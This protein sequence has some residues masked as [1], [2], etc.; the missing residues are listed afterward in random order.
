MWEWFQTSDLLIRHPCI[1]L[2]ATRNVS[3]LSVLD[4]FSVTGS[5][6]V[7]P[8]IRRNFYMRMKKEKRWNDCVTMKRRNNIL[9]EFWHKPKCAF[10][11][12]LESIK[13]NLEW[14]RPKRVTFNDY[15][16]LTTNRA[17]RK[18]VKCYVTRCR[19]VFVFQMLLTIIC[20]RMS[21]V[22]ADY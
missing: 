1:Q 6:N 21:S 8:I 13:E 7:W 14:K 3:L 4:S 20:S 15:C 17:E 5:E 10:Q 11:Y 9:C 22:S 2:D 18:S 19:L 16:F 12:W